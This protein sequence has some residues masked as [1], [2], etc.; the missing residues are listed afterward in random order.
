MHTSNPSSLKIKARG[1]EDHGLSQ[2]YSNYQISLGFMRSCLRNIPTS[3]KLLIIWKSRSVSAYY[4]LTMLKA[5]N[6]TWPRNWHL[7]QKLLLLFPKPYAIQFPNCLKINYTGE[8][9]SDNVNRFPSIPC[10]HPKSLSCSAGLGTDF[11]EQLTS[12]SL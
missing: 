8:V 1:S 7:F 5:L 11:Y 12:L 10:L 9:K 2:S 4:E 6:L 3:K